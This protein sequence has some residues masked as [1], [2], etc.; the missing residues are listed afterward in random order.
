MNISMPMLMIRVARFPLA[1]TMLHGTEAKHYLNVLMCFSANNYLL[2]DLDF[3][4]RVKS[5]RGKAVI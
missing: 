4:F 5:Y 1:D 3:G 2:C